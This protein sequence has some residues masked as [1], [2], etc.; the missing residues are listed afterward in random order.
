MPVLFTIIFLVILGI[1]IKKGIDIH[2]KKSTP[3][4]PSTRDHH[5][6]PDD[7]VKNTKNDEDIKPE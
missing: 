3:S 7:E 6:Q 1:L 4:R 5:W 2:K